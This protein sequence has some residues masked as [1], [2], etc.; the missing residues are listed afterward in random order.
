MVE[1]DREW[2]ERDAQ[3]ERVNRRTCVDCKRNRQELP[4]NQSLRTIETGEVVCDDCL[5][6]IRR[7]KRDTDVDLRVNGELDEHTREVVRQSFRYLAAR[8]DGVRE[9]TV[10]SPEG[11]D[12][13]GLDFSEVEMEGTDDTP[14]PDVK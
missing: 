10:D 8:V 6:R 11:A 13:I 2:T 4:P 14:T 5:K 12:V 3:Q 9:V 1:P 7:F